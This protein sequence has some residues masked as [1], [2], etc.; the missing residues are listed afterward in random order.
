MNILLTNVGRRTYF[1]N[2][3]AD[4]IKEE[5]LT[6]HLSDCYK[7]SAAFYPKKKTKFHLTCRVKSNKKRYIKDILKITKENNINL[8]I[9]LSDLDLH[10]FAD[11]KILEGDFLFSAEL[12]IKNQRAS[13]ASFFLADNHFGF[14]AV[15]WYWH[16]V[17]VV[18][19]GLFVFVYWL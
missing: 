9:P 11:S 14:E 1:V 10:I 6:I 12:R 2:F 4:L 15:A 13:A 18:W 16:F 19:L 8:I 7:N 3:L 17:D 5:N